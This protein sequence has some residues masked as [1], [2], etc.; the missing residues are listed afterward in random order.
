MLTKRNLGTDF[1]G[2]PILENTIYDPGTTRTDASGRLVR[3]PFANNIIPVNRFDPVSAKILAYLPK[4][5]INSLV[6]NYELRFPR[7]QK[8]QTIPSIKIDHALTGTAKISVYWSMQ[9]TDK[10]NSVN[11]LPDPIT[12]RIFE[13]IRSDTA[14]I[15]YDQS[16]TPRLM[17]H[18]GAGLQRYRDPETPASKDFD[19]AGQFGLKGTLGTGFPSIGSLGNSTYGGM[20]SSI[21]H[22]VGDIYFNYKPTGVVQFTWVRGN[23]TYK[24]GGEWKIDT[25]TNRNYI[26]QSPSLSFGSG[27]TG[28]PLYGQTL[29]GGTAIGSSFATFLLGLYDG[30]SIGNTTDPQY[31]KSSW[32]FYMQ[33]TWKVARRLTI[34]YGIRYDLQKPMRELRARTSTFRS[35]ILNPNANG[36]P[37]AT[38]YE[39]S[40]AGRC[41]CTLVSTYP[42]AVAP[43]I[44]IAYKIREKTVLRAGWGFSYNQTNQFNYIGAGNSLGMGF[45]TINF[46]PPQ[47]GVPVGSLSDGLSYSLAALYAASYDPGLRVVPGAAVQSA[48]AT[49]DPNGGRPPRVNQWN[50]SLQHELMK[51][52]VVEGAY[53][54]NRGVWFMNSNLINYN[55]INP[56]LYK[57]LNIDFT[58]AADRTL[59][60]STITSS[61]AVARGFNKPYANFPDSGSVGPE[62]FQDRSRCKHA[63]QI[64]VPGDRAVPHCTTALCPIDREHRRHRPRPFRRPRAW[65]AGDCDERSDRLLAISPDGFEWSS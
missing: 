32:A 15:N 63:N 59:L 47:A 39:G 28:Q 5:T 54:G 22:G 38:Q 1:A 57:N 44:G 4:P 64:F 10:D 24:G 56:A 27:V 58:N 40:G 31:R 13:Y 11:G 37:G 3:E 51:D 14:R 12:G 34:D 23:H 26:G 53:V 35:V 49:V 48:P 46:V 61:V 18:L 2:R 8:I 50:I 65:R 36:I 20:S 42:Y 62:F 30:G 60:T 9:E 19:A 33:D 45:N 6:N 52:L 29:P 55:A 25:L 17:L 21:G 16:L 7:F 41:N 43:R